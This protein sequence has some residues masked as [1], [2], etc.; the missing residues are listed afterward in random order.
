MSVL[1]PITL[2]FNKIIVDY[3]IVIKHFIMTQ[4]Y[5]LRMYQQVPQYKSTDQTTN[6]T[7]YESEHLDNKTLQLAQQSTYTHYL[8]SPNP[9]NA[10]STVFASFLHDSRAS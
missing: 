7:K 4:L 8:N 10:H 9:P 6:N 2:C 5:Y 3:N 1:T